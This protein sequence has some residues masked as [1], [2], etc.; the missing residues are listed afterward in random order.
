[1]SGAGRMPE[2]C[3]T[4]CCADPVT[5]GIAHGQRPCGVASA[6]LPRRKNDLPI[7]CSLLQVPFY[8][9]LRERRAAFSVN[10]LPPCHRG[11][12]ERQKGSPRAALFSCMQDVLLRE[13]SAW[14]ALAQAVPAGKNAPAGT[15]AAG[16]M[17]PRRDR[18]S[19]PS[20]EDGDPPYRPEEKFLGGA[21]EHEGERRPFFKK[22][23]SPPHQN[24]TASGQ[25][26]RASYARRPWP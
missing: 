10:I 24:Y 20:S 18:M 2:G 25:R 26:W 5:L 22:V 8:S 21:G 7:A 12:M 9:G 17:R 14:G 1:M 4:H 6:P 23:S 15:Q 19:C 13:R 11:A 3:L 16:H